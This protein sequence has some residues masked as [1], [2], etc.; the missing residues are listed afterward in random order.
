MKWIVYTGLLVAIGGAAFL[1]M[2]WDVWFQSQPHFE[3]VNGRVFD[4][5]VVIG[6]P[7]DAIKEFPI[8]S[9]DKAIETLDLADLVLGVEI[10]G[11]S[12]AYPL[13][14]LSGPWR[15]IV[16]DNLGGTPIAATW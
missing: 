1:V 15:E 5:Q 7:Y 12:R 13:A 4:P 11:E 6:T 3:T 2:T 14:H 9:I 8:E 10:N 16:N